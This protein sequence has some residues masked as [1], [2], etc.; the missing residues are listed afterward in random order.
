MKKEEI[1][2]RI[3][4]G[5]TDLVFELLRL[6][7]WSAILHEGRVKPLRWFVYYNDTTA[8]KAVLNAG[9]D[10]SSIDLNDELGSASFFGHWKV[11]DFL[12]KHGADVNYALPDSGETP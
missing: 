3:S 12:I 8:L 6:P 7:D 10:L 5:R 9:G 1:L 4:R 2:D 11:V